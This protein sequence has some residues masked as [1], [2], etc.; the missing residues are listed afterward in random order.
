MTGPQPVGPLRGLRVLDMGHNIT[1]PV[2][3]QMLGMLGADVV[4]LE[5]PRSGD[6]SRIGPPFLG[7]DGVSFSKT[8]TF[9][10]AD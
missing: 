5:E 1:A 6:N 9:R 7:A 10:N 2:C 8:K 3:A 4:K